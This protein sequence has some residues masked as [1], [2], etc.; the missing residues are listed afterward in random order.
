MFFERWRGI[1]VLQRCFEKVFACGAEFSYI[2][3]V[4]D[5]SEIHD[6]P[7]SRREQN[8]FKITVELGAV[9]RRQSEISV[10]LPLAKAYATELNR[11][12]K[13]L[14]L[15]GEA[16]VCEQRLRNARSEAFLLNFAL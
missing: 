9:N 2:D 5:G 4:L 14:K 16:L 13:Q 3:I 7:W 10:N 11:L 6:R 1:F 15:S 8:G 12:A